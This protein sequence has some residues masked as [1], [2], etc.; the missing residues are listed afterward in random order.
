MCHICTMENNSAT[1]GTTGTYYILMN[2]KTLCQVKEARHRILR[3]YM[4]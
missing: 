2:P 4:Y 3:I 1:I